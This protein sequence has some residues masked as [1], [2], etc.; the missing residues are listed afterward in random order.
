MPVGY[1]PETYITASPFV[2]PLRTC[3]LIYAETRL[4][5]YALNFSGFNLDTTMKIWVSNRL[6][7]QLNCILTLRLALGTGEDYISDT[8][9]LL[10]L[11]FSSLTVVYIDNSRL[12]V[13]K[14][15]QKCL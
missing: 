3:R 9:F 8:R 11:T 4:R 10:K 14:K 13:N 1:D 2:S 5:L 12:G 6:P 15:Y 7:I